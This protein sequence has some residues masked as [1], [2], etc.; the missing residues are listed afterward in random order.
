VEEGPGLSL[1][2]PLADI[3]YELSRMMHGEGAHRQ[4]P[5]CGGGLGLGNYAWEQADQRAAL[6][7]Q[8][9]GGAAP[10]PSAYFGGE[11]DHDRGHFGWERSDQRLNLANDAAGSQG[12]PTTS[13]F[14]YC[15]LPCRYCRLRVIFHNVDTVIS[16]IDT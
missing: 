7:R 6:M 1:V 8:V 5:A 11:H 13:N 10:T 16:H 4:A 15:R 9:S 12:P 14:R 3:D 2:R